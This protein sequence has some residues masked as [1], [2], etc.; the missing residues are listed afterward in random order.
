[1]KLSLNWLKEYIPVAQSPKKIGEALTMAGLEIGSVENVVE[2]SDVVL[3]GEITSNRPDWLSHLGVAREL[4]ALSGKKIKV[5]TLSR[6]K[7]NAKLKVTVT[8]QSKKKCPYYS[9]VVLKDVTFG[10]SPEFLQ[11]RLITCGLRPINLIVDVTN[12]VLLECGQPLHAFDLDLLAGQQIIVRNA[13]PNEKFIA[14]NDKTYVLAT[15]DLVI[16]DGKQP[17]A[18]AGVMGG[19]E[20]EVTG[21]TKNI[22][23]E[24]AYFDPLTVRHSSRR[25]ALMSD[26][27]YRFERKVDVKGVDWARQRA[28]DLICQYG[29]VGDVGVVSST[30][31]LSARKTTITLKIEDIQNIL[32]VPIPSAKVK[33]IL[34]HLGCIVKSTSA[35]SMRVEVPS[36]RHDLADA[37]DLIE[38]IARIYGYDRIPEHLP[39]MRM[40]SVSLDNPLAYEIQARDLLCQWGLR[41]IVPYSFSNFEEVQKMG[42]NTKEVVR[43]VNPRNAELNMMRISMLDA[44]MRVIKNNMNH[45]NMDLALFEIG[46]V[47]RQSSTQLPNEERHICLAMTGQKQRGWIDPQREMNFFDLKGTVVRLLDEFGIDGLVFKESQCEGLCAPCVEI[48]ADGMAVG[49][50]GLVNQT[51]AE[52]FDVDQPIYVSDLNLD[53]ILQMKKKAKKFTPIAKFPHV[54]RDI[55]LLIDQTIKSVKIEQKIKSVGGNLLESVVL[56]DVYEGKG[57]PSDKRSVAFRMNFRS[58]A[59][60][61][62]AEEVN[63]LYQKITD[64]ITSEFK[65]QIR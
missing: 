12:Y 59:R 65:A 55:A 60:T 10:S 46:R 3:E 24:S 53:V 6:R 54:T 44:M 49:A 47:Y 9:C 2:V 35:S 32:A 58:D 8:N 29:T 4:S 30:G 33:S 18:L 21:T 62:E 22:L 25:H 16:S 13:K 28:V 11:K 64:V 39:E 57:I 5:P 52:V 31:S 17:V 36:F 61:L 45:R 14:I 23:I 15:E 43:L 20:S 34:T 1:M 19:K 37:I 48:I 26:S 50:I 38:E 7:S 41:E 56:F 42:L 51:T 27:S 40:S 63:R